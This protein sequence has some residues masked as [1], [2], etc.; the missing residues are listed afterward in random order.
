[1]TLLSHQR[2]T[3]HTSYQIFLWS[4]HISHPNLLPVIQISETLF[5]FPGPL[6][7]FCFMSPWMPDGNVTQY[8]Q[9]NPSANRL[10][11]VLSHQLEINCS[12]LIIPTIACAGV[13]GPH[14]PSRVAYFTR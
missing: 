1:V 8:T 3:Q 5:P 4:R 11:L 13:P 2:R 6:F 10:M 9:M 7:P 12:P 14:A